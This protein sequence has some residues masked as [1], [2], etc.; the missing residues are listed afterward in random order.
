MSS[1]DYDKI[2]PWF[3]RLSSVKDADYFFKRREELCKQWKDEDD[4][5]ERALKSKKRIER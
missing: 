4:M 3:S 5:M 2:F 1:S